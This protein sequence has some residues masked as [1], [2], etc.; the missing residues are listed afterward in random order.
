MLLPLCS[1]C[2]IIDIGSE[3]WEIFIAPEGNPNLYSGGSKGIEGD[4]VRLTVVKAGR[5]GKVKTG[6][7][8]R[9]GR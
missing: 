6:S 8:R 7:V 2:G 1:P 3:T 5:E 4:V 9:I